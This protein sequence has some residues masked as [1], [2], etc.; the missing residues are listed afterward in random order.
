MI[1]KNNLLEEL[2]AAAPI[3]LPAIYDQNDNSQRK[4]AFTCYRSH[5]PL[6]AMVDLR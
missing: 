6:S 1:Q 3:F 4:W 2:G 5:F